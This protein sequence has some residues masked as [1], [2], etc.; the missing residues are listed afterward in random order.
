MLLR[1]ALILAGLLGLS[2]VTGKPISPQL[3]SQARPARTLLTGTAQLCPEDDAKGDTAGVRGVRVYAFD[4]AK[5]P[6]IRASLAAL[7][8]ISWSG[9]GVE[10]M[11]AFSAEY[12][13]LMTV[14][15]QTPTLGGA[16]SNANGEFSITLSRADS[17]LLFAEEELEDQPF[18]F[19]S[20][21][22]PIK[23]RSELRIVL[24]MCNKRV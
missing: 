9:D 12:A 18:F 5:V 22:V 11:H 19:A 2:T 16:T 10:A 23:Q 21:V 20:K 1:G 6:K 8:T 24:P 7:D 4:A 13:E 3:L 15:K 14:L 17:V